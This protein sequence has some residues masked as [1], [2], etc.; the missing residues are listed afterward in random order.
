MEQLTTRELRA[1]LDVLHAIGESCAGADEFARRGVEC[2]PKL[3]DADLTTLST[4]DLD[5]GHRSVVSD[6]AAT[7]S[8]REI[9]VFDH[10]FHVH[11]LVREHGRNPAAATKRIEDLLPDGAFRHTPLFN[12]YYRKIG[13]DHVMAVPI[14]VD[15]RFLVSLVLNR[16]G[17]AFSD[18]DRDL[19]EVVRPHLA[20]LYRLG[21]SSERM[22]QLP[23]DAPFDRAA[24]PLTPREREVLDWVAAGKTNRDIAAILGASPRTVEKHLER[25]YE[26]LGVETRTAAVVRAGIV[27]RDH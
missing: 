26:K 6:H 22:R 16:S 1:A 24:A 15:R 11:P 10:Y 3:I 20:N 8:R 18:R 17:T 21:V 27:R 19:A 14:H 23:A 7:I 25:I 12:E 5:G 13:I 4:C 2:L 9:D